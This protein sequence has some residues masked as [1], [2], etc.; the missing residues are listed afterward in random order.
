M[1]IPLKAR[2]HGTIGKMKDQAAG[3]KES[4]G[5][6]SNRR[7]Q[8]TRLPL[9]SYALPTELPGDFVEQTCTRFP[10]TCCKIERFDEERAE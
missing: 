6:E 5:P 1:M 3:K 2:I 8:D 7:P 4:P 10:K 9:Q